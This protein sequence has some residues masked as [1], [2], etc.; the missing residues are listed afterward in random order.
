MKIAKI[1]GLQIERIGTAQELFSNTSFVKDVVPD[2]FLVQNG[3]VKVIE[4]LAFDSMTHRMSVVA[5]YIKGNLVYI[6]EL[7]ELS[8]LEKSEQQKNKLEN[9]KRQLD[10]LATQEINKFA[11]DH[12]YES[13]VSMVSFINSINQTYVDEAKIAIDYRDAVWLNV[14]TIIVDVI[15]GDREIPIDA[16]TLIP[17]LQ[18]VK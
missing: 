8:E 18:N 10:Y 7:I 12:G 16:N 3:C 2:D 14:E 17:E 9:F 13:I 6:V 4:T 5:P 11:R 15:A 1:N